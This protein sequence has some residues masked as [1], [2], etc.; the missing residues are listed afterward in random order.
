MTINDLNIEIVDYIEKNSFQGV[1]YLETI[2]AIKELLQE[3][4]KDY[5]KIVEEQNT[6]K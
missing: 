2:E 6:E 1:G 3:I 4:E 5:K